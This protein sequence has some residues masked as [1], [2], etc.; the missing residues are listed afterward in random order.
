MKRFN[1][2]IL[3]LLLA[4]VTL[5]AAAQTLSETNIFGHVI[6]AKTGEHLPFINVSIEGTTIG[7]TSNVD[8]HYML[9]EVPTGELIVEASAVGYNTVRRRVVME[10]GVPLELNIETTETQVSLDAVVVSASRNETTKREA[11]SLVSILDARLFESA[12]AP[13]LAEGLSFQ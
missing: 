1:L 12:A 7:T 11:P 9:H 6:N 5:P 8:G 3:T 13:T 10:E 2:S 4:L